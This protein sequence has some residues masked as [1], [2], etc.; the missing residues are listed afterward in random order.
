MPALWRG[1]PR[2]VLMPGEHPEYPGYLRNR[3]SPLVHLG[4]YGNYGRGQT[5]CGVTNNY[6]VLALLTKDHV[7]TCLFCLGE[8]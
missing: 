1:R 6:A 8:R 2:V 7:P 3:Y 5:V 4:N